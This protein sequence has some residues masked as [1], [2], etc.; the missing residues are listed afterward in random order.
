M[1]N[2]K[3]IILAGGNAT[4]LHPATRPFGKPFLP[5]FDKPMIFYPLCV[6][7]QSGVQDILIITTPK[8]KALFYSLLGDGSQLGVKLSY[9]EQPVARGIADAFI[10][11]ESFID[12]DP[13]CLIL[14]D[15]F[16]YGEGLNEAIQSGWKNA[17]RGATVFCQYVSNPSSYGVAE[18]DNAG[19]I[20]RLIE[21]PQTFISHWAVTG[22]YI[23]DSRVCTLAKTLAPS[24]RGELEI[25]DLNNLYLQQG[26]LQSIRLPKNF[27][28]FDL[29]TYNSILEASNLVA[30]IE[31]RDST[32]IGC[33]YIAAYQAGYIDDRG[34]LDIAKTIGN[35]IYAE[36]LRSAALIS[37][38]ARL[39]K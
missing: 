37:A 32:R 9:I 3:G 22:L 19:Q 34:L 31:S 7:L 27:L 21:K 35:P 15:N 14:C 13:V 11:G 39:Y 26:S 23:Y 10:L 18:F 1:A 8:D 6:L 2:K 4:R 5:I 17:D 36:S 20:T 25:T 29:G 24:E 38:G 16:F 30:K 12:G 28:W 33:P